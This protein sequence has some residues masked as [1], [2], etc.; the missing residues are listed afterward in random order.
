MR[1]KLKSAGHSSNNK[2][3]C[4]SRLRSL[5]FAGAVGSVF[6][7]RVNFLHGFGID[8]VTVDDHQRI[9]P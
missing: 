3:L 7:G 8:H 6:H 9:E 2:S 4:H 5:G 1:R